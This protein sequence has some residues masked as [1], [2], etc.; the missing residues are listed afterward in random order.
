M[1]KFMEKIIFEKLL[2]YYP[3]KTELFIRVEQKNN[4]FTILNYSINILD[5]NK[6][7]NK[8]LIWKLK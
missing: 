2:L 8:E 6:I 5:E 1:Y 7:T 3:E 4:P